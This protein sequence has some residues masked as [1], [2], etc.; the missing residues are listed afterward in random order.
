MPG[1][2]RII[3]GEAACYL[4]W[5]HERQMV[6]ALVELRRRAADIAE[7]ELQRTLRRLE[8]RSGHDQ[9]TQQEVAQL[10]HRIVAKLLHAPTVRLK[11]QAAGGNGDAYLYVLEDL[12]ALD[13]VS[14]ETARGETA[15][16]ETALGEAG[17]P[18]DYRHN[19]NG[20]NG[21]RQHE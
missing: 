12:F 16:G 14:Y 5:L 20:L 15:Q 13:H 17:S 7:A 19:R 3:A 2:E 11:A 21:Y 6:P 18:N 4:S 10:A 8:H 1:V 9:Q